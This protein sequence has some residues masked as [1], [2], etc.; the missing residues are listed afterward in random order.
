MSALSQ[1]WR[2]R[3]RLQ[4]ADRPTTPLYNI[5]RRITRSTDE[6]LQIDLRTDRRLT[7]ATRPLLSA[8]KRTVGRRRGE[9]PKFNTTDIDRSH[10]QINCASF[11]RSRGA[12]PS[13][14]TTDP[15]S[16]QIPLAVHVP[17]AFLP[18]IQ[19]QSREWTFPRDPVGLS[20]GVPRGK[21]YLE[22]K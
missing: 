21:G 5:H 3:P 22:Q 15:L 10:R 7:A 18:L 13:T 9:R 14:A 17:R 4:G 20:I 6:A 11:E 1:G 16:N 12:A 19:Q 8:N 2:A